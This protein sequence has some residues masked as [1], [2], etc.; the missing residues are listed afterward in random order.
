VEYDYVLPTQLWPSLQT[1]ELRGLYL[2]GQINGTSGYE[3]AAAQGILAGINA[4][5]WLDGGEP[6]V[7]RRDQ[8]YAGVLV[9]DLVTQGTVEPYR[10]FTSRAEY[11][12]LLREDNADSRLTPLGRELGLVDEARWAIYDERREQRERLHRTISDTHLDAEAA[13]TL[14]PV[15]EQAGTP[16]A[17]AGTALLE[18][19]RRPEVSLE[20]LARAELVPSSSADDD[21]LWREQL[22]ISVKYEGYIRRQVEEA[23]RMSR[24]EEHRLPPSLD[25]HRIPGLRNEVREKLS[26]VQPRTLGQAARIPG[27]TP[28]AVAILQIHLHRPPGAER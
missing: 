27:V 7:L 5:R 12:L 24:L 13:A 17:R 8:A 1:K 6:V 23:K 11:R 25:Y 15:L 2:A 20:L 22:E 10:M 4:A 26:K 18:L 16:P 21:S 19:L 28:A 14:A 3:E 9:D